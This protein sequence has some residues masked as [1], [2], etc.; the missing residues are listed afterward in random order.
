M[1][2]ASRSAAFSS[3][4]RAAAS[5]AMAAQARGSETEGTAAWLQALWPPRK[6]TPAPHTYRAK[7]PPFPHTPSQA[8]FPTP[9]CC[10]LP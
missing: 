8:P 6:G 10:F 5:R 4:T 7:C 3:T 9:R 1:S 2:S